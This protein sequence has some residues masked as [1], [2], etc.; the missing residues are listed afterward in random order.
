VA[1]QDTVPL[2]VL[3]NSSSTISFKEGDELSS[4]VRRMVNEGLIRL[5]DP[6]PEGFITQGLQ[7]VKSRSSKLGLLPVLS[8]TSTS[9]LFLVSFSYYL[10]RYGNLVL[11]I[12]FFL[13]LLLIFVPNVIR[14]MSST[15]SRFERIFLLCFVGICFYL[16][17]WM[18]SPLHF[19]SFDE[20]L[21]WRT[22][23]DIFRSGH[24][25]S[26]NSLLPVSPYYPGLEIVTNALSTISGLI[27][28]NAGIAVVFGSR[29]LMI[30]SLFMLYE[31]VT[32]SSRMAGIATII[33]M[34]NPHFLFFDAIYSYESFA[35]PL[36]IFMMYILIRFQAKNKESRW[37]LLAAY[38]ALLAI[39]ITHHMTD[40]FFVGVLIIWA[41]VSLFQ[42][43]SNRIRRNLATIAFFGVLISFAYTFL[44]IGNPA[45]EYLSQYF[46][47]TINELEHIITGTST[48]RRL[49]VN[50]GVQR[51]PIWDELLMAIS[52]GLVSMGLPFGLLSLWQQHRHNALAVM[53]GM[54]SLAYPISQVFRF[55]NF[56]AEITDRAAA[57]LFLPIA[58]V[59]TIFITHFWPTRR[60]SWKPIS[61]ITCLLSI[62]FLGGV[63]I[64]AG[65]DFSSIPGPYLVVADQRSI[66]P[67]GIQ[68]ASWTLSH[69]GPNNV[70][71][72]D[73]I[74]QILMLSYGDQTIV[75]T[76]G[77][78]GY[79]S[80][81]FFSPQFGPQDVEILRRAR[82]RYLVVD[83]RLS[84][85]LPFIGFYFQVDEPDAFAL[86]SPISR[87]ALTK[88]DAI[89]QIKRIYDSGDIVIY[90]VGSL[91][92]GSGP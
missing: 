67:E 52:V 9:G 84:T 65:P 76:T 32:H 85:S 28:F 11:E 27:T 18:V 56:G 63:L 40:F 19:S 21:H 8:L 50:L 44:L 16:V 70:I 62:V 43:T 75:T 83:Q 53:F 5:R 58:Y 46:G 42:A 36:A 68:T 71:G 91:T 6:Q 55:T 26:A 3:K 59:L 31:Q 82:I 69:L 45:S 33:Y 7:A 47:S 51:T 29:L 92:G 80:T 81:V 13:G 23:D 4:S 74:N 78:S 87:Q 12:S 79:I 30:L 41:L 77:A 24:L 64:E 66:E 35:L 61:L 39:T 38:I 48:A 89:P 86:T 90:D 1:E 20:F 10:S 2:A 14:L 22:A 54:V 49:F 37:I 57:F 72:T 60:L 34:I 17:Q 25:F 73:R 88:F 15:P